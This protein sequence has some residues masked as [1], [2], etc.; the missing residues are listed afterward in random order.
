M[1]KIFI[2]ILVALISTPVAAQWLDH[3]TPGLPRTADGKPNLTAPSPRTPD[4]KPDLSG[5]WGMNAGAYFTN[6]AADLNPGE[7]QP[8]ADALVKRRIEDLWK[9][10]PASF[11]CL[12][13]GP[14]ASLLP[15]LPVKIIQT[16]ALII[17][18]Y[19]DL[20]HRQIFLDGRTLPKDPNP[21][22]MG[23]SVGR[24]EGNTLVVESTGFNDRTWLDG[25]GH[26]HTEALRIT[27][28]F[29]R[30]DFGHMTI[31]QTFTD[32]AIYARPFTISIQATFVPD[33]DL[34]EYVCAENEKDHE[35]LVGKA[36]DDKKYAVKV[37]PEVL[38]KY[39][40]TYEFS[41][42]ENP[43][44]VLRY[45]LTLGGGELFFDTEGKDKTALIP[46]SDTLFSMY[47]DRM[48]IV[49]DERGSVTHLEFIA[50][51]GELKAT[52]KR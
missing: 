19:E 29:R 17:V 26:P 47:G 13:Q 11:Q 24:W 44:L 5:L 21:S 6:V 43:S 4:G 14:R 31:E 10:D 51:E 50:A 3:P 27:E 52:R 2:T 38:A 41:F 7:I 33:T 35:H 34:L 25:F 37:T 20:T 49:M 18:L 28:R 9:D 22:F 48:R 12:P 42:P 46:L 39:V 32:P 40:G 36:S 8:W 30:A 16:P 15:F 45:N 1:T 23:Y